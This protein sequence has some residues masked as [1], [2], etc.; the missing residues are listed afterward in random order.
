MQARPW[1]PA[2]CAAPL[3]PVPTPPAPTQD[4]CKLLVEHGADVLRQCCIPAT[5]EVFGAAD[6]ALVHFNLR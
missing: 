5:G 1:P 6:I 4:V 2:A 3:R